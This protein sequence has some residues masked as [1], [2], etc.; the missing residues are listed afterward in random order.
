MKNSPLVSVIIATYKRSESL[1]SAISS[2]K[3][4]VYENVEI[5][6]VDD[7]ASQVEND[8]VER[9]VE[10][11]E[12]NLTVKYI[13]NEINQGSA[14]TRNIG[15]RNASGDYITFLDD[16]DIY[17]PYKIENQIKHMLAEKSDYSITDI[18]LYNEN[19]KLI[20]YRR[21]DYLKNY[22]SDELLKYHLMY[23]MTGTDSMMFERKYLIKIGCF[24]PIN[25]GDEFHLMLNA[26]AGKGKFS[27]L[28]VCDLKAYIH[29]ESE[30]LSSGDS[31]IKGENEL[32]EYKKKYFS[33][34]SASERRYIRMRHY[35][36]LAYAELRRKSNMRFFTYTTLSLLSSPLQC[37][38]EFQRVV[39]K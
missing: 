4:Q 13:R 26:I 17:L 35:A 27:Y 39:S 12:T 18:M 28:P 15:I 22:N 34:I 33:K 16:D 6:I 24:P 38:K 21:R 37:L 1:K 10:S 25:I 23:H 29:Y 31:K 19:D 8:I 7:N 36:V 14:E 20:E 5:I 30:G 3:Q 9:I 11:F 2:I 32:Y